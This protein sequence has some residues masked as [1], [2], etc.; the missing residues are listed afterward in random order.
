VHVSDEGLGDEEQAAEE[1]STDEAEPYLAVDSWYASPPPPLAWVSP[2]YWYYYDEVESNDSAAPPPSGWAQDPACTGAFFQLMGALMQPSCAML[3]DLTENTAAP[4]V[5]A[6]EAFCEGDCL[7]SIHALF[8]GTDGLAA[9]SVDAPGGVSMQMTD[10][11]E[12]LDITCVR[13]ESDELCYVSFI[14]I[15]QTCT[16]GDAAECAAAVAHAPA[17]CLKAGLDAAQ[18]MGA[19]TTGEEFFGAAAYHAMNATFNGTAGAEAIVDDL[20]EEIA[21][22]EAVEEGGEQQFCPPDKGRPAG[23]M[24]HCQDLCDPTKGAN[25]CEGESMI[26]CKVGCGLQCVAGLTE[27]QAAA[28][29]AAALGEGGD[30]SPT[31]VPVPSPEPSPEPQSPK[32]SPEPQSP[33]KPADAPE[34]SAT[35]LP[36]MAGVFVVAGGVF[37]VAGVFI[38]QRYF[39]RCGGSKKSVF[40]YHRGEQ[41]YFDSSRF[42][43]L[44]EV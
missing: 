44:A 39:G 6:V 33:E 8:D 14:G 35:S 18:H 12:A 31:P 32:A 3:M 38:A 27:A 26:C 7:T 16:S 22:I 5:D 29:A 41:E 9:C 20:E 24:G 43:D 34:S 15:N 19:Y 4:S 11:T 36:L 17:G 2:A 23:L 40:A 30:P 25:A 28:A 42:N 13:G 10:L 37:A 21:E 1:H